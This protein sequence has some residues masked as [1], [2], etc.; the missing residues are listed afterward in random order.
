M[1]G[2]KMARIRK[3]AG[4]EFNRNTGAWPWPRCCFHGESG[5]PDRDNAFMEGPE[6]NCP[7]GRWE[8]LEPVDLEAEQIRQEEMM[9]QRLRTELKPLLTACLGRLKE[10]NSPYGE[11]MAADALVEMT[12]QGLPEWLALELTVELGLEA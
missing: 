9:Q 6:G 8:N 2:I 1:T 11:Q 10:C 12:A 3:C 7:A 5:A 4:C